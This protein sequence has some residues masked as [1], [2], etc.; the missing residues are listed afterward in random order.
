MLILK[1]C[2][3]GAGTV[4]GEVEALLDESVDIDRAMLARS[5]ARVQ[6]HVL[7]DSVCALAV[8]N[9]LVEIV[10]QGARQF[11]D[12]AT[13]LVIARHSAKGFPQFVDQFRRNPREIVDKIERVFDLVGDTGG[14]LA[15]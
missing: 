7:H 4:I 12:F 13:R 8:L 15:K 9:D 6:Q 1:P 3:L 14:Q 2:F 10:A 11:G 5:F